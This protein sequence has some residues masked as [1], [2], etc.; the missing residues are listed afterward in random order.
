[1]RRLPIALL[2]CVIF[3]FP[4]TT[5]SQTLTFSAIPDQD[6]SRLIERFTLV[7]LYLEEKLGID[8][9]YV[10]VKSYAAAITAFR[11][12]QVQLAWFGGLS[13]VQARLAVPDS[14]VLAQGIEDQAF[15]TYIIANT[16]TEVEPGPELDPRI[17][18]STFTFGSKGSTS[19]RLM[20][21]FFLR[22]LFRHAPDEL[23]DRVGFSGDHSRTIDLVEAGAFEFGAVNYEVWE[24]ELARGQIDTSK[25][26]VIWETPAYP[27]Y[28]WTARGDLRAQ[29]GPDIL[30]RLRQAFLEL[31]DP[32]V[33]AAFPRSGFV[34]AHNDDYL[35]VLDIARSI[36]LID[37]ARESSR[38]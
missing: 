24:S 19:G 2:L 21:E 3:W 26:Q 10:P 31:D 35:P 17:L 29:F 30:N 37:P 16:E 15:K 13:G 25:V 12:D 9:S 22:E 4:K 11:N 38:P 34:P 33:L 8:V 27:D 6:E 36:G 18:G 1:M 20:P 14:E 5:L 23:F 7:E 32:K 28:Q